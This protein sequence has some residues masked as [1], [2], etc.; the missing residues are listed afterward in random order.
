M[1]SQ[2]RQVM[3]CTDIYVINTAQSSLKIE[4]NESGKPNG[5]YLINVDTNIVNINKQII[6]KN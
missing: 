3:R 1:V 6:V 5:R 2:F 4:Q